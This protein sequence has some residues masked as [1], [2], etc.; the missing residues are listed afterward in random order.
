M[1]TIQRSSISE[2]PPHL[3]VAAENVPN[4]G[5]TGE[6][7]VDLHGSTARVCEQRRDSFA[8]QRLHQDV[9]PFSGL[10]A[11]AVHPACATAFSC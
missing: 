10:V 6:G 4:D 7:L 2:P 3:F 1:L 11:K 5:R 8:L 9:T